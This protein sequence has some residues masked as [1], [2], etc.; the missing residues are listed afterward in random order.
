MRRRDGSAPRCWLSRPRLGRGSGAPAPARDHY[1]ARE[2]A[3]GHRQGVHGGER[4]SS[5]D[6]D[7]PAVL[8]AGGSAADAAVA[9][10]VMLNSRRA[11]EFGSRRRRVP[12]LLGRRARERSPPSMRANARPLAATPDYWLRRTEPGR[13]PGRG[14]GRPVGR[15]SGHAE[16]DRDG[17]R[18]LRPPALGRAVAPAIAQAEAGFPVSQRLADYAIAEAA[19][20]STV[21]RR[22]GTYFFVRTARRGRGGNPAQ[23]GSRPDLAPVRRRGRAP[24]YTGRARARHRRGGAHREIPAS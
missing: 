22:R 13:F 6:R 15:R 4:A 18:P 16:A 20:T 8:A 12:R 9:V 2:S 5:R 3:I 7:R 19:V 17:A 23:P 24:F 21:C 10:Q 1:R 11:A 14:V